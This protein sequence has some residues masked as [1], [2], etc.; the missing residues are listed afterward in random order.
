MKKCKA[1]LSILLSA[2]FM[3]SMIAVAKTPDADTATA[4]KEAL[5]EAKADAQPQKS[6]AITKAIKT[7]QA[8]NEETPAVI[9]ANAQA[10]VSALLADR[11]NIAVAPPTD[12][13]KLEAYNAKLA[14]YAAAL[15]AYKPLSEAEKDALPILDALNLLK[16][17][18]ER[19]GYCIK[20]NYDLTHET[21]MSAVDSRIAA[22]QQ[23]GALLGPHAA[24]DN[25]TELGRHF[26]AP[27]KGTLK[28]SDFTN[29]TDPDAVAALQAYKTAFGNASALTRAYLDGIS[30]TFASY[31]QVSPGDSGNKL[32]RM[33]SKCEQDLRPFT[34][35]AP[36]SA[37]ASPKTANYAG[38]A[39][40]PAYQAALA[41]WL[42]KQEAVMAY[43]A[44]Q[45]NHQ[46]QANLKAMRELAA[47]APEYEPAMTSLE[48]L[49][50]AFDTFVRT[51]AA[52]PLGEA[53]A[54]Y[55]A[56]NSVELQIAKSWTLKGYY[57]YFL[58]DARNNYSYSNINFNSL[59][60][61]CVKKQDVVFIEVFEDYITRVDL[62][63]VNND[64]VKKTREEYAKVRGDLRKDIRPEI[65]DKYQQIL[66]LYVPLPKKT[67]SDYQFEK[68]LAA[69]NPT[70]V[71]INR[72]PFARG[73][74]TQSIQATDALA[75]MLLSLGLTYSTTG[76]IKNF[77]KYSPYTNE[78]AGALFSLYETAAKA[79][80]IVDAGGGIKV[81]IS[82]WIAEM[83]KPTELAKWLKEERFTAAREKLLV[84]VEQEQ[85]DTSFYLDNPFTNGDFG[86][87]DGDREGF[88]TAVAAI[89]RPMGN[90][91][92]NGYSLAG[93][94]A[95]MPNS[96]ASNGDFVYGSYDKLVPVLEALGLRDVLSSEE[97]SARYYAALQV[98]KEAQLDAIFL[99][100]LNNIMNLID[101]IMVNPLKNGLDFLVRFAYSVETGFLDNGIKAFL[102]STDMLGGLSFDLSEAGINGMIAGKTFSFNLGKNLQ[103]VVKLQQ[104]NFR[105]LGRCG[106]LVLAD[107]VSSEYSHRA[108]LAVNREDAYVVLGK[109]MLAT[110]FASGIEKRQDVTLQ[111]IA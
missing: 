18:V 69:F 81:N 20:A 5:T 93:T 2:V 41:L 42:T 99:P 37:G 52:Q 90:F 105:D 79:N 76:N 23:L 32:V 92:H 91:L 86:F 4:Q 87:E 11:T 96:T 14:L 6:K 48:A 71:M 65:M 50:S 109:Y 1:L 34:E 73:A 89:L 40:D 77:Q 97:Y 66:A 29:Y 31:S 3:V 24:R 53:I 80:L 22:Q 94:L 57:F 106:K 59:Y 35:S 100:L 16:T 62:T 17:V 8:A 111:L 47:L 75:K 78:N 54:L 38:G 58:N 30:A 107:S 60:G 104:I 68:E 15:A 13:A 12:P 27:F 25:A 51:R 74:A 49:R 88:M 19:E 55:D 56:L 95:F 72:S 39:S 84:A 85:N 7:A 67:A 63:K 36:P 101:D 110:L 44:R 103:F 46:I 45:Y 21:K 26:Y 43:E 83:T 108:A 98:S 28:L 33:I 64:T 10:A 9:P 70:N 102:K 82:S 61:E